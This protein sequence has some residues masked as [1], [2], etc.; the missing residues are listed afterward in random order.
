MQSIAG[1]SETLKN[2]TIVI[3]GVSKTY[4]MTGWRIGYLAAPREIAKAIGNMQ[5]HMTSNPNSIAQFATE[6]ALTGGKS[7]ENFIVDMHATFDA[8]RK[9]MLARLH[10]IQGLDCVV[11]H[12]AFY[13]MVDVSGLF[14]RKYGDRVIESAHGFADML[15]DEAAVA[16]IPGEAFGAPE[17]VRLS[18]AISEEDILEG[19]NRIDKFIAKLD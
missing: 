5:S 7:A 6:I 9:A 15:L 18:Y 12:G 3:N 11:P 1:I 14:G 19:L 10:Q 2:H 13:C 8:R 4:A 16:V 17:Y